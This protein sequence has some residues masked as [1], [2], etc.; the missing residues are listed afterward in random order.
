MRSHF[1]RGK[2]M[3][4]ENVLTKQELCFM[5]VSRGEAKPPSTTNFA[6]EL[7]TLHHILRKALA[8]REGDATVCPYERNLIN[9]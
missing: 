5:Y 3:H 8:P 4:D 9:Y 6:L 7:V 2:K 1:S